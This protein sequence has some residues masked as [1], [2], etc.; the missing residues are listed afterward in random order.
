MTYHAT[1]TP[2]I[3]DA[4][5]LDWISRGELIVRDDGERPIEVWK[6]HRNRKAY[7]QLLVYTCDE[8]G[9]LR[10]NLRSCTRGNGE[11]QRTIYLNKLVWLFN[12]REPV[13]PG[14]VLNHVDECCTNDRYGNLELQTLEESNSQ[15]GQLSHKTSLE[16]EEEYGEF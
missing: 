15:G 11:R 4:E 6:W 8:D 2:A 1:N 10:C 16:L 12:R 3:C 14:Y 9:R 5:I 13:P 7:K